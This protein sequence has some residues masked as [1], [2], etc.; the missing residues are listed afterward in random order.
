[1]SKI[2]LNIFLSQALPDE[3]DL[4]HVFIAIFV[5]EQTLKMTLK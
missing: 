1:M 2:I 4:H 5:A 3:F